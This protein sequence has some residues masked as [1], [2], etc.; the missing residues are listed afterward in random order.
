MKIG[1]N[2]ISEIEKNKQAYKYMRKLLNRIFSALIEKNN[3]NILLK[4]S[5]IRQDTLA[6]MLPIRG[7]S[8]KFNA[9]PT[10]A[11]AKV[12]TGTHLVCFKKSMFT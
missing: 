2:M 6:P 1:K 3:A 10:I 8:T 11:E 12:I 7:M 9:N 4:N 5:D